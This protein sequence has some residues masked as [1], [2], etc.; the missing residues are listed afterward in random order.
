MSKK[1]LA[2]V[3]SY[4]T[5][6][7]NATY[8]AALKKE[9]SKYFDVETFHIDNSYFKL[10]ASV[11]QQRIEEIVSELGRFDY[12][13]IQAEAGL[14]GLTPTQMIKNISKCMI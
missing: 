12:V 9:F 2:I 7:G 13:N 8:S 4:N 14:F 11:G 3:S 10:K 5:L 1:K 6:C